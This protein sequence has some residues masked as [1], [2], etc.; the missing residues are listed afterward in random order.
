MQLALEVVDVVVAGERA[1]HVSGL[2][3]GR[4]EAA[5]ER[6]GADGLVA[7]APAE[8]GPPDLVVFGQRNVEE[9]Q[10][11]ELPAR[12]LGG[13]A[14]GRPEVPLDLAAVIHAYLP[15]PFGEYAPESRK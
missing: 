4:E 3:E 10:G 5:V 13:E 2:D 7:R 8:R 9:G 14:P 11:G 1:H 6:R 12:V 15:T